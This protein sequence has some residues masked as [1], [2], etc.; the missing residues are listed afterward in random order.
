MYIKKNSNEIT[1]KEAS[2]LIKA[3][4]DFTKTGTTS[5]ECPRCGSKLVYEKF[6]NSGVIRC[7]KEGC[8][9][10]TLRGL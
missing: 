10:L 5:I 8:I 9:R 2:V 3:S 1:K 6:G 7:E 4:E